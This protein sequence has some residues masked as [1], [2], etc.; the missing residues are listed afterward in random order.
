MM[1]LNGLLQVFMVQIKTIG[2]VASAIHLYGMK[3]RTFVV[4]GI[5]LGV[6]KGILI[7]FDRVRG[8]IFLMLS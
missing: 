8:V 2:V 6:L 3:W 4:G 1:V 7:L 5:S